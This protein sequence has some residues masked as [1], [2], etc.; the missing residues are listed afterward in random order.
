MQTQ[1][2]QANSG[3]DPIAQN[4]AKNDKQNV[5]WLRWG[6]SLVTD[7]I[8]YLAK[9]TWTALKSIATF[10]VSIVKAPFCYLK[11][12]LSNKPDVQKPA[13]AQHQRP[14]RNPP[15]VHGHNSTRTAAAQIT[16]KQADPKTQTQQWLNFYQS[17][18]QN[19]PDT[20]WSL[21]KILQLDD[22]QLATTNGALQLL[23]PIDTPS[24][25]SPTAP[26]MNDSI[27]KAVIG[28]EADSQIRK[29]IDR[30]INRVLN[31]MGLQ[32]QNPQCATLNPTHQEK[33]NKWNGCQPNSE[34]EKQVSRFLNFLM[35]TGHRQ[36][37]CS[38]EETMNPI[39][40]QNNH[41]ECKIWT[42]IV[43]P[44]QAVSQ[45]QQIA[46]SQKGLN[47]NT[48]PP[49]TPIVLDF[50]K[51][52]N[53]T[54]AQKILLQA[55]TLLKNNPDL[56]GVAVTYSANHEQ[57]L[58]IIDTYN[59]GNGFTGTNGSNQ[60]AVMCEMEKLLGTAQFKHLQGKMRIAPITT[61]KRD[62]SPA[63]D[64]EFKTSI[65]NMETLTRNGW[66]ILGWQNQDTKINTAKPFAIGGGVSKA[67]PADHQRQ[68]QN[69]LKQLANM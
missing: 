1:P 31:F 53:K 68:I 64:E 14:N 42:G 54:Q 47:A 52:N 58:K 7:P 11:A 25:Y 56:P 24:K 13:Q 62:G 17:P 45:P 48:L 63:S 18:R 69:R 29:N 40:K 2:A 46:P 60:A 20:Q 32:R 26:L 28:A 16:P 55:Q 4:P 59:K 30:T 61:M 22:Q 15:I 12:A 27:A 37:A 34:S 19:Y 35:A 6:V 41:P 65:K 51:D 8:C 9:H 36:L 21:N 44:N 66:H 5:G 50:K 3:I 49:V 57:T 39:R 23:M 10:A 38:I 67:M 43:L 33:H